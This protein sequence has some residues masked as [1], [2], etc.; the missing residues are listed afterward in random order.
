MKIKKNTVHKLLTDSI[1][2]EIKNVYMLFL[3]PNIKLNRLAGTLCLFYF[4][5]FF[6][7]SGN[8]TDLNSV[9]ESGTECKTLC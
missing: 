5:F 2:A 7:H 4:Q 9:I 1:I 6:A 8:T 3:V